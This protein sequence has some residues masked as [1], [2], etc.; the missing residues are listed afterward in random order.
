MR[1]KSQL[2]KHLLLLSQGGWENAKKKS[3]E[4]QQKTIIP[5]R[6]RE[7]RPYSDP[8]RETENKRT[9]QRPA[10]GFWVTITKEKQ[11]LGTAI[12]SQDVS[13]KTPGA[14]CSVIQLHP[15]KER[16]PS[17]PEQADTPTTPGSH[18]SCNSNPRPW[19]GARAA[20][21]RV[22]HEDGC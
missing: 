13:L 20:G 6:E 11:G 1:Q 16:D 9:G 2:C 18:Q 4:K 10:P 7:I 12:P 17:T 21:S 3:L 22:K 14:A 5:W 8:T 19:L 15:L